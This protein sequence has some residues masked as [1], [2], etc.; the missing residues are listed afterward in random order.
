MPIDLLLPPLLPLLS[1][2]LAPHV[3]VGLEGPLLLPELL[4]SFLAP[5]G[6]GLHVLLPHPEQLVSVLLIDSS[7][8]ASLLLD[9]EA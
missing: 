7:V 8:P 9:G 5:H 2:D 4:L 1:F 3:L 6:L